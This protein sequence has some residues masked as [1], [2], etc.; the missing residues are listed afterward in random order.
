MLE[1]QLT[2]I[3]I[4]VFFGIFPLKG[5]LKSESPHIC[6]S[7]C[8]IDTAKCTP[9]PASHI[10]ILRFYRGLAPKLAMPSAVQILLI[11]A[12]ELGS[13]FL[14]HLSTLPQT[15][16]TVRWRTEASEVHPSLGPHCLNY[17]S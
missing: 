10:K 12:G 16:V 14:P 6:T 17:T 1:K 8:N 7:L 5:Y 4:D 3:R 13:A 11:G 15:H 2:D 9:V